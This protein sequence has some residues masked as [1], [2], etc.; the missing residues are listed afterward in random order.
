VL[1]KLCTL[2]ITCTTHR[3]IILPCPATLISAKKKKEKTH[4]QSQKN[5]CTRSAHNYFKSNYLMWRLNDLTCWYDRVQNDR[6][7]Q[8]FP[9]SSFKLVSAFSG[10]KF[11]WS[12]N[13]CSSGPT[14]N[15]SSEMYGERKKKENCIR[16]KFENNKAE[17]K[18]IV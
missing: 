7:Q 1:F 8:Y 17:M 15:K 11:Q 13:T 2:S 12:W 9:V 3:T 5:P 14:L 6:G 10:K 18:L 4:S 16:N